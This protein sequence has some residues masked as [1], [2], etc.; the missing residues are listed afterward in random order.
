MLP[1]NRDAFRRQVGSQHKF[2]QSSSSHHYLLFVYDSIFFGFFLCG[3]AFDLKKAG[4][5][6]TLLYLVHLAGRVQSTP[7]T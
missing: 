4:N 6:R 7:S 2:G 3:N 5:I 1:P